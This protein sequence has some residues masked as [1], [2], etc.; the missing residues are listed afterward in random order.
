MI[1]FVEEM[2]LQR[3]ANPRVHHKISNTNLFPTV[4]NPIIADYVDDDVDLE[5]SSSPRKCVI[6]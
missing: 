6:L 4:L 5:S 3:N 1:S 2:K